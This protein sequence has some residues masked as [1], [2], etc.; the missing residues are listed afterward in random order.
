MSA[1]LCACGTKASYDSVDQIDG[2]DAGTPPRVV[3][4]NGAVCDCCAFTCGSC[5]EL[6]EIADPDHDRSLCL[7][8]N[9]MA[10][11]GKCSIVLG[12]VGVGVGGGVGGVAGACVVVGVVGVGGGFGVGGG[13]GVSGVG[14]S[15]TVAR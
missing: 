14:G 4:D 5:A 15:G 1:T 8:C 3:V 2:Y 6:A 11:G 9:A 7:N 10:A 12:V 13:L